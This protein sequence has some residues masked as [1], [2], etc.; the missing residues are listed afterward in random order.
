M[1]AMKYEIEA[2]PTVY[3]GVQFRSRLE[4]KW[5][6][7]FDE[8]RWRWAYEPVDLGEW[9]PDFI[10]SGAASWRHFWGSVL[11]QPFIYSQKPATR[12]V[13]QA[14]QRPQEQ[15]KRGRGRGGIT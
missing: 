1:K 6:A 3:N 13:Q 15:P 5:A 11:K 4:A 2:K 7:F 14:G 8:L 12:Q 10:I 9:S